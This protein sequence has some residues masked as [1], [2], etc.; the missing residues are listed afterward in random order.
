MKWKNVT[1][2]FS[3]SQRH[4]KNTYLEVCYVFDEVLEVS[5]FSSEQD[6]YEIYVS[7]GIMVGIIYVEQNKALSLFE[8]VKEVLEKEYRINKKPTG[9]FIDSFCEKYQLD[10]P[11]DLFFDFNLE[12]L[13]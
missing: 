9:E 1:D 5:L 6:L 13:I 2:G 7:Y 12:D 4:Y 11:N 8:E 3:E 10:Y